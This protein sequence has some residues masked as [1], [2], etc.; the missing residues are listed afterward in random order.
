MLVVGVGVLVVR[1]RERVPARPEP[2]R[3]GRQRG[4]AFRGPARRRP[5]RRPAQV[6]R[7]PERAAEQAPTAGRPGRDERAG[8]GRAPGRDGRD[9]SP[10]VGRRTRHPIGSDRPTRPTAPD[11]EPTM[12]RVAMVFTGGTISMGFDPVAGGNVPALDGAAILART[13]GLETIADI[14][15][16]D[17]GLTPASHFTF[18]DVLEIGRRRAGGAGRPVDRRG[19]RR[20]GHGHDRGDE[21]RL[22]PRAALREAR[23]RDRRD[24]SAPRGGLR[25]SGQPARRRRRG[26][27][28]RVARCGRRRD[29]RRHA[30]TRR[31]RHEAPHDR[32]HDIRVA[33]RRHARAGGG[34]P[35]RVG[36]GS[37]ASSTPG[38]G[39]DRR[40]PGPPAH[41]GDRLGRVAAGCGRRRRGRRDRGRGDRGREH[42][43]R[44]AGRRG[45]SDGRGRRRRAGVALPG[46][47]G[48]DRLCLS[49][50]RRD[51]GPRRRDPGR[52]AVRD[53]GPRGAGPRA[54]RG[55]VARRAGGVARGPGRVGTAS[56]GSRP[57]R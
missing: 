39:P 30:G 56:R 51:V 6:A 9:R 27:V 35:R 10:V 29:A 17:R 38:P 3:G 5:G 24:A 57:N 45:A 1:H 20:P 2:G 18:E 52:D 15:T 19:R 54:R 22:G 44:L 48:L 25:R 55:D 4:S 34:R 8:P 41:G 46:R 36:A 37:R 28:A 50:R 13:P 14:V 33:Q 16:V 26:R 47:A 32:V 42:V 11:A 43:A 12:A 31:R 49:G 21:L 7:G 53:Q 40:R 23:R